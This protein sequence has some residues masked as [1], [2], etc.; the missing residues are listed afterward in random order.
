MQAERR[1]A[2]SQR[3]WRLARTL[4]VVALAGALLAAC[5]PNRVETPSP[6][7]P[8][9]PSPVAVAPTPSPVPTDVPA[10]TSTE[11]PVPSDTPAPSPTAASPTAVPS[12]T[13]TP[14]GLLASIGVMIDN[15]PHARPQTGFNAAS[16]VY[17]MPAEFDLTRFLAIYFADA[18]TNVGSMRSTRPYFALAM[19]E[20][21]GGLVGCL[22]VPGV[23]D[24]LTSANVFDFDVC[25]GVG[26]EAAVRITSRVAPFN[27]YVNARQ[28]AAELRQRPPRPAAA[29]QPRAELAASDPSASGVSLAYP[30]G[31][32]VVWTWNGQRFERQQDGAPHR[33]S[34]GEVVTTDV[35]VVQRAD[36]RPTSYF[37][38]A[39][40]HLVTLTGSGDAVLVAGG[41]SRAVRWQRASAGAPTT[42]V[43]LSGGNVPLPPGRVFWEVVPIESKVQLLS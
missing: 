17:E 11:A 16:V 4:V 31:H 5:A 1:E 40:Y 13:A 41:K 6:T 15:D 26:D 38:E 39:G 22:D 3:G 9:S 37:G 10:P 18:P 25:R 12:I 29:L 24:I 20:Y 28:L 30:D 21:G 36:T 2:A 23:T 14:L 19:G 34:S 27:L 42:L 8:P 43:D 35:V 33:E 32:T 7:A